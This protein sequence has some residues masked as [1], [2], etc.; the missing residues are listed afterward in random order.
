MAYQNQGGEPASENIFTHGGNH[1][2]QIHL[3]FLPVQGELPPFVVYRKVSLNPQEERPIESVFSCQLP[4]LSA[5]DE[6]TKYWVSFNQIDGFERF[7]IKADQ[8]INLTRRAMFS[9]ILS[10]AEREAPGALSPPKNRFIQELIFTQHTHAEGDEVLVVQPYFLKAANRFGYLFDFH[11]KKKSDVPFS[12]EVQRLSLSLDRNY[13]R[14]LNYYVD[15]ASNVQRFIRGRKNV[16]ESL[17]LPGSTVR[18]ALDSDFQSLEADRLRTKIYVFGQNK[19]SKSQFTGLR[20]F[21]PLSPL[22]GPPRLLF[23]FREQDREAARAL[24]MGLQGK[25][26][27]GR[28]SFPGFSALFKCELDIDHDPVVFPDLS[29]HSIEEA[30][31][32]VKT[33]YAGTNTVPVIILPTDDDSYLVQKA[34]FSHAEIPTQVCT[35]RVLQ[36]EEL[37]K[38][39]LGNLAL[40]IFCKAGGQPWKVRPTHERCLII[41]IS[42]SHKIREHDGV[43]TIERYFAFSV[44]T[45]SSGLFQ[46]ILVLGENEHQ[47]GYL[48]Q[49]RESL[50][51]VLTESAETFS[52]IV[53][54]TSFKLKHDEMDAIHDVVREAAQSTETRAAKF[55]VVKV[56]QRSRF[57]GLN[58]AVNSLVP[59]EA[60]RVQLG[61]REYLI[62]FEG[63]FPDRTTVSKVFPG[64]THLQILQVSEE[65]AIPDEVLLQD[66]VNLSGANWRG[67]NA[68]STPVSVFYCHLIADFVH[69]FHERGLPLPAVQD[70][71]PWF[72]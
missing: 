20:N 18:F 3:N 47:E 29:Q 13:R 23:M 16:L 72:L 5:E 26:Q 50:R 32:R 12:R 56:N 69:S 15:R 41:G 37:M 53:V 11:F 10:A 7:D 36:D 60:T 42:Q 46:K 31:N 14:N 9:A 27:L 66:L 45:D 64:P 2:Y 40:Q 25:R 22:E 61:P 33:E 67:F 44:M 51:K 57:F 71:R 59:Y 54:H 55:A 39:S 19:D 65:R 38:W 28:F 58:K 63:I 70:I 24:A 4:K 68:K 52:R 17:F 30:L 49:L 34:L 21:G 8:N 35:L 1:D 62:W 6:W 43:R 48:V